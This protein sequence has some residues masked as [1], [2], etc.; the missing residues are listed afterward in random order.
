MPKCIKKLKQ[1]K[2]VQGV[3]WTSL[4]EGVN[5]QCARRAL[6][7]AAAFLAPGLFLHRDRDPEWY[8]DATGVSS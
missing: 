8:F 3:T 5:A 4:R 7:L 6:Q 1:D 2:V